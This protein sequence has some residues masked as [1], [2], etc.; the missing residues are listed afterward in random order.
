MPYK[1]NEPHR[2]KIPKAKYRVTNWPDYDRGLVRRGDLRFW[3]DEAAI[4]GWAAPYRGCPGGQRRY[5]DAAISATLTLGAVFRLPLRQSE[6][7]MRSLFALLDV[8]LP[9]G[10]VE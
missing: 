6:G 5:S 4:A 2:G 1:L 3:I 8:A 9:A 10:R 7:L